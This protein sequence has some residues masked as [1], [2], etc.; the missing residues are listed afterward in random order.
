MPSL[1]I[2]DF[3]IKEQV[4]N[5]KTWKEMQVLVFG[6]RFVN[7]FENERLWWVRQAEQEY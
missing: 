7:I 4:R 5:A 6:E 3:V 2:P 1:V